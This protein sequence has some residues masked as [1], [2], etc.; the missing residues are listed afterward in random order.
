MSPSFYSPSPGAT[1]FA[2]LPFDLPHAGNVRYNLTM[3]LLKG[4]V[5]EEV[6]SNVSRVIQY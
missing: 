6:R 2:A 4:S 1:E 5:G 3:G